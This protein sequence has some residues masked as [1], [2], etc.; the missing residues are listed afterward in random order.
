LAPRFGA[1]AAN[2]R[3]VLFSTGS[4]PR[5]GKVGANYLMNQ[6]L[7]I[8]RSEHGISEADL[9]IGR[10]INFYDCVLHVKLPIACFIAVAS[11]FRRLFS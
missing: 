4:S 11:D 5:T 2:G 8:F 3:T 9:P 7:F 10:A 1:T 6:R